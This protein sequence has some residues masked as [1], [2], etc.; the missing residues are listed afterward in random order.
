[1]SAGYI[2]LAAIGQQDILLTGEPQITYFSGVYRRHTPFVLEAYDIPFIGSQVLYGQNNICRIPPKGDLIRALTLKMTLPALKTPGND[3]Y[4][5]ILIGPATVPTVYY[6]NMTGGPVTGPTFGTD[7][8][9]TINNSTWLPTYASTLKITYDATILKF[10]FTGGSGSPT[11]IEV[12]APSGGLFWGLDPIKADSTTTSGGD[13]YYVY[14]IPAGGR[15]ADFTVEQAGWLPAQQIP[16]PPTRSGVFASLS[17][18]VPISSSMSYVN[19]GSNWTQASTSGTISVSS[20]GRIV[21][22]EKGLYALKVGFGLGSGSISN[23]AY[24][25]S[26]TEDGEPPTPSFV[27]SYPWRVSPNPSIPAILPVNMS[28]GT[29]NIYVY[30]SGTGSNLTTSS[31]VSMNKVDEMF[32]LNKDTNLFAS[33]IVPFQ[34]NIQGTSSGFSS[35]VDARTFKWAYSGSFLINGV[36]SVPDGYVTGVQLVKNGLVDYSYDMSSQGAVPTLPF[37][38][39]MIV[40][41]STDQ[42]SINVTCTGTQTILSNSYFTFNQVAIPASSSTTPGVVLPY[43]GILF[44]SNATPNVYSSPFNFKTKFSSNGYPYTVNVNS[45][46]DLSFTAKGTYMLTGAVCTS[47]QISSM[48]VTVGSTTTT[49]PV[50]LGLSPPYPVNIPF[51]IPSDSTTSARVSFT[52]NAISPTQNIYSNTFLAVYP[53]T[54]G[55]IV[56]NQYAY[57]DSVG[58]LAITSAELKIGGQTIQKLTGEMIEIWHDLNVSYENQPGLKL[59]IGKGDATNILAD[60][61]YYVNLPFYFYGSP[62]LALPICSLDRQDVEVHVTFNQFSSLTPNSA[63][64]NPSLVATIIT[65]YVYLSDPEINWFRMSQIDYVITQCQY[66]TSNLTSGFSTG[67]FKLEFTNPVRELYFVIQPS[68]NLPYDYSNNGLQSLG[69]SL[70]GYDLFTPTTTDATYVGTLEPFKHFIN[71]PTRNFYS[72]IMC[73]DPKSPRPSGYV[74]LSRV[75]QVLL[76]VNMSSY[77]TTK[78]LRVTAVSHNVLRIENGIAGLMFNSS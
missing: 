22:T 13:T 58:T 73:L 2:Q 45:S 57:Y 68:G 51:T 66:Y 9:S 64:K 28:G 23:V 21:P 72:Y 75:K 34:S 49:Y 8:Y 60:R 7:Y 24:G 61:T 65:E 11:D 77:P 10:K 56:Y 12:K 47:D 6:N 62:E 29:S 43:Q 40:T 4:W 14:T 74:N 35:F 27:F 19:L 50:G 30:A 5:P 18:P 3:W 54:G 69:L 55:S 70:N 31:Y 71:F 25:Y 67:I 16:D 26:T 44:Q 15:V 76:T 33:N 39:P 38:M 20:G 42:Y 17:T 48:S 36:L 46:G 59:T 37:T 32:L 78:A 63:L 1:M 52:V 41:S 53:I